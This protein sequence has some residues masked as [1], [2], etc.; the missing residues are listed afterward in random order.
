MFIQDNNLN[1]ILSDDE[2]ESF[3]AVVEKGSFSAA[4]IKLHKSQSSIS[5]SIKKLEQKFMKIFRIL[6]S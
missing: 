3:L 4:A 6:L 2:I 5:Y 1:S